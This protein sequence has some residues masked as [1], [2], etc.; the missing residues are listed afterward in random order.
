M[1]VLSRGGCWVNAP[2]WAVV[3]TTLA[4]LHVPTETL[5][6]AY[7]NQ[8]RQDAAHDQQPGCC[9]R[10][11]QR[12][13]EGGAG[14]RC[15]ASAARVRRAHATAAA[16]GGVLRPGR[17]GQRPLLRPEGGQ[18]QAWTQTL[19]IYDLRTNTHFT[20]KQNPLTRSDLDEFVACYHP[21][22][23]HERTATW[24]EDAAQGADLDGRGARSTMTS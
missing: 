22:N 8:S 12:A 16:D 9:G 23:R 6:G 17:E 20:L 4:R 18:R 3:E 15:G 2:A 21:G 11:R 7:P 13:L 14:R 1:A 10:A 24:S 19:W 5:S